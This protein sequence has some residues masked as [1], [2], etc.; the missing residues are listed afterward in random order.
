MCGHRTTSFRRRPKA[1]RL[2]KH[3]TI[4]KG[5]DII[6]YFKEMA[7][8]TGIPYQNLINLY[9]RDCVEHHRK[10]SLKWAS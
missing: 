5:T 3:V 6:A 1:A 2:K 8:E 4:R 10:L 9:L 7:E